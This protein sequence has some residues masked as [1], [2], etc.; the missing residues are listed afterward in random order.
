LRAAGGGGDHRSV[1]VKD[2]QWGGRLIRLFKLKGAVLLTAVAGLTCGDMAIARPI[3][4]PRQAWTRTEIGDVGRILLLRHVTRPTV[5]RLSVLDAPPG[6]DDVATLVEHLTQQRDYTVARMWKQE[7]LTAADVQTGISL[8]FPDGRRAVYVLKWRKRRNGDIVAASYMTADLSV[9]AVAIEEFQLV[10]RLNNQ[11]LRGATPG[12]P[13]S[14][15]TPSPAEPNYALLFPPL[16]VPPAN[17]PSASMPADIPTYSPPPAA[18]EDVIASVAAPPI[19]NIPQAFVTPT[20]K[21]ES[22]P[23]LGTTARYPFTATA[24][25]GIGLNQVAAIIYAPL[26][27]SEVYVL[28]K[29]GSFHENLP[30]AFE[31]WDVGASKKGDPGSWGKWKRAKT[32]GEYQLNY[33]EGDVVDIAGSKVSPPETGIV[34]DGTYAVESDTASGA[35][36]PPRNPVAFTGD[37]FSFATADG[38]VTGQYHIDGYTIV[39]NYED[40]RTEKRPFFVVPA[41]DAEDEPAIWFGDEVKVKQ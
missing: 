19:A 32:D 5:I 40:G 29:D 7:A 30:V 4:T 3:K 24:G 20:V 22:R 17:A 41:Q 36:A 27:F 9:R 2:W 38:A 11:L 39:L 12:N 6:D 15:A 13:V 23:S 25:S 26:E 14:A 21:P 8:Q 35:K 34:L 31:Q 10:I 18:Q 16:G 28:F 1:R 33:G 37:R